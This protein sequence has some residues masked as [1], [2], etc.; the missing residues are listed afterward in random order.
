MLKKYYDKKTDRQKQIDRKR[1]RQRQIRK[2][3]NRKTDRQRKIDK[4]R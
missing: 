2:Y 1:Y 3:Y 4:N